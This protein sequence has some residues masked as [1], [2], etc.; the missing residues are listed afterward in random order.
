VTHPERDLGAFCRQ[1]KGTQ[2][3]GH[4]AADHPQWTRNHVRALR[5]RFLLEKSFFKAL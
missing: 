1:L 4:D 3:V 2:P 5:E